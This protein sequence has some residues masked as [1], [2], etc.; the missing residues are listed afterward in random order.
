MNTN[1]VVFSV[2]ASPH[3]SESDLTINSY[4]WATQAFLASNHLL[5]TG[6]N[7]VHKKVMNRRASLIYEHAMFEKDIVLLKRKRE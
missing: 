6:S 2:L 1:F 5:Y 4:L 7:F 3:V